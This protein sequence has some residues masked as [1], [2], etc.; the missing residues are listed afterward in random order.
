[1][2]MIM[3]E[4]NRSTLEVLLLFCCVFTL[5]LCAKDE[6]PHCVWYGDCSL[7]D[8]KKLTCSYD[9]PPKLIKNATM[10]ERLRSKCPFYFQD[11]DDPELCCDAKNIATLTGQMEMIEGI[12]G[13]CPTCIENVY[14]LIC[15]MSC[16]PVQSEF[17]RV[18]KNE[19]NAKG[20]YVSEIE[21]HVAE[22]YMNGTYN[23]CKDIVHP[24]SGNLAMQLACGSNGASG[25][26]AKKWYEYQGDPDANTFIAFRVHFIPNNTFWNNSTKPCSDRTN[27]LSAC[28]CTDCPAGCNYT[29]NLDKPN[30]LIFAVEGY[31]VVAAIFSILYVLAAVI[32]YMIVRRCC[33]RSDSPEEDSEGICRGNI[34]KLFGDLFTVCG[35]VFAT[36]PTLTLFISSYVVLGLSY[37]ITQLI[38]VSDPIEIWAAPTSRARV[39]KDYFDSRF[40]PFYRTEQIYIKSVGIDKVLYNS[41]TGTLE[42]GPVFNKT[43]LLEVYKL[44]SKIL[45]L[46]Q[47]EGEG[48]EHFCSAP[49]RNDFTGPTTVNHCTIQSIWGYFQNDIYKVL[50]GDD[51]LYQLYQC[52]QNPF[53]A[54][55]VAPYGGPILP[56]VA[57]GGFLRDGEFNYDADDYIKATGLVISI[58]VTN[59]LD[60]TVLEATEKWEQRFLDFMKEWDAKE[61]PDFMDVAYST[62]RSIQDELERS[63]KAEA[64]TVVLSYIIMFIYIAIALGRIQC[65]IKR[66]FLTSKIM[67]SIGGIVIVMA[68]VACSLGVFGYIGV[69]TTLLT[70][71]VIPFLV[72]AI[73]VDNIFILVQTH[74]RHPKHVEQTI[75]EH[76]ADILAKVG[77]SMLLT[78]AS[79]CLCFLIGTLSSMPAV[80]TFALYASLSIFFN[81]LLQTTAFVSLL[82]L[83]AKRLQNNYLDVLCCVKV[84]SDE[85]R[86]V[87]ENYSFVQTIFKRFYTPFIMK[88]PVRII[89]LIFFFVMLVTHAAVLPRIGIGLEQKLSMPMDSYVLKYFEY[90]QDLLS[91]GPPVYFV[92][93]PG[94]NYS[95]RDVQN[96]ICGSQ[97]CNDDSMYTQIYS[98]AKQSN[99]SYLSKAA[100]S[101]IDDYIDWSVSPECCMYFKNNQSFCPHTKGETDCSKCN[102][103]LSDSRPTPVHFQKYLTYFLQDIPDTTCIKAGRPSYLEAMDYYYDKNGSIDI[104]DTYFMGYHTPL[105]KSSDW[106]EALKSA[107]LIADQIT[108]MINEKNLTNQEI[109]VFPYSVFYVYYEQYLTIWKE[110]LSSLGFSL[111]VIFLVTALLTGFSLFSAI[112]VVLIVLMIIVNMGGLMYWWQIEL[113]AVSLVNLVMAVG[114]SVEFCSHIIHYYLHSKT[115]TS[116]DRAKETLNE[117]GSSVFSGITLTKI[118]GIIVLAFPKTQIF[119]VFYFRM[120]FGIVLFGAAHGL[121]LLPVLLSLI[122]P[123]RSSGRKH[124]K[125]QTIDRS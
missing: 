110:A 103:T 34:Q 8:T 114:I 61:R 30:F 98:A 38:V 27:G 42:F 119:Q 120:Y 44:Q 11:T 2:K 81:F 23:S 102:I 89:V 78:S 25:C 121:I 40:Q 46:G 90:M 13:R 26:T 54:D 94:L 75:P 91:M 10:S 29:V 41:S 68:S 55:C 74:E 96:I 115:S 108:T 87:D 80:N 107:R 62:E 20:T 28:S 39:E 72:L 124:R 97:R 49:I 71:E 105:K 4:H 65:S 118:I 45:E 116:V 21:V 7:E 63:S 32:S 93:T 92:I 123:S 24:A 22:E 112:M 100:S 6:K 33:R 69:P 57:F 18:L 111:C 85:D 60:K 43:F 9:G 67:L 53:N 66:C 101:W 84:K 37:G 122:G 77:P 3:M 12:F 31:G 58:M 64:M 79:E 95:N 1:M 14:K 104:G 113:N 15:D 86:K 76:V 82:S 73:G 56:A 52:S 50:E 59:S 99:R 16:S 35:R 48:L 51:Y 125:M 5:T 109:T 70:I 83:D 47:E 17:L 117:V 36:Y 19:T 88:K 106:Y